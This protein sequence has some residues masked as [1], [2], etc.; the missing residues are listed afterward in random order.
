ML[1][2]WFP[3]VCGSTFPNL[4]GL[5]LKPHPTE[6]RLTRHQIL[7]EHCD[8]R[9]DHAHVIVRLQAQQQAAKD[10]S[11]IRILREFRAAS[12]KIYGL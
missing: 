9:L 7:Y 6:S 11:R 12:P 5:T 4:A 10:T 3:Y 8:K 1:S 2:H